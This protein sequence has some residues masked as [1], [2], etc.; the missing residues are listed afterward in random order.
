MHQQPTDLPHERGH[1][2]MADDEE[3][4]LLSTAELLRREGYVVDAV[5]SGDEAAEHARGRAFDLV[6]ADIRMA[7]N[8]EL[9]LVRH[10]SSRADAPPVILVT[11]YPSLKTAVPAVELSVAAYLIK[12]IEFDSFLRHVNTAVEQSR[13]N[14][15]LRDMYARAQSWQRDLGALSGQ[16][17]R[18]IRSG[19]SLAVEGFTDLALANIL[20][21]LDDLRRVIGAMQGK[22]PHPV[23]PCL[24]M[25]CPRY[26]VLSSAI[27]ETIDVL[28]ETKRAFKSKQLGDL[29]D[30]LLRLRAK[31]AG[32]APAASDL[33]GRSE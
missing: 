25:N 3:S 8:S 26:A 31:A 27:D 22:A 10:L 33:P 17:R 16:E 4:F 15:M 20:G 2:L 32:H 21:S 6:I 5:T 29:K 13:T 1:I 30:R 19:E 12:P 9:Q 18:G 14:R 11:G 7:G 23:R 24:A 28:E